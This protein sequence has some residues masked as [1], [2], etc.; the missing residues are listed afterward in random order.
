ME[1]IPGVAK[2]WVGWLYR[3][4][5]VDDGVFGIARLLSKLNVVFSNERSPMNKINI[6][7]LKQKS[8]HIHQSNC[9]QPQNPRIEQKLY[10]SQ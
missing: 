5:D 10:R 3:G 1:D 7:K 2:T 4:P 9:F 8:E 6:G